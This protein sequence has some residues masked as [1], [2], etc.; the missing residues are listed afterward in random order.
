MIVGGLKDTIR[1][2][3]VADNS[4]SV[5]ANRRRSSISS[6][7]RLEVE[8]PEED[9]GHHIR[10]LIFALS[11]SL[12]TNSDQARRKTFKC[13]SVV[14]EAPA[15]AERLLDIINRI[16]AVNSTGRL[17]YK[18]QDFLL[19]FLT[20]PPGRVE[21]P[22]I[23]VQ[24]T[25]NER[26]NYWTSLRTNCCKWELGPTVQ[27]RLPSAVSVQLSPNSA[28]PQDQFYSSASSFFSHKSSGG[29]ST[30]CPDAVLTSKGKSF[31]TL[32]SFSSSAE[33]WFP[34]AAKTWFPKSRQADRAI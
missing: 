30:E 11:D 7:K 6:S 14:A 32:H 15:A 28:G 2:A 17:Q 16:V 10:Q 1:R 27:D 25:I 19:E 8:E 26:H 12:T 31:G 24:G 20:R 22:E 23:D 13:P 4:V 18:L 21:P 9:D 3:S 33:G 29:E 5:S 34:N